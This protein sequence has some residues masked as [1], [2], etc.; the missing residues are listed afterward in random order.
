MD[1]FIE[2]ILK[3]AEDLI[4]KEGKSYKEMCETIKRK[5]PNVW[6]FGERKRNEKV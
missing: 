2:K 1:I 3:E 6:K 4:L 5:Y